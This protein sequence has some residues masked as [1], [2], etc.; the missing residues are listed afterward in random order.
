MLI[1]NLVRA[2]K[3]VGEFD[4]IGP[5]SGISRWQGQMRGK[6]YMVDFAP[7]RED[8]NQFDTDQDAEYFGIWVNRRQL[9]VLTFCEGDWT[10]EEFPDA[11]YFNWNLDLL[12]E[13]FPDGTIGGMILIQSQTAKMIINDRSQLKVEV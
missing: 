7:D 5:H 3:E 11:G 2:L 8:W 4:Q 13:Q 12:I 1:K 9:Q 6:R 10:L